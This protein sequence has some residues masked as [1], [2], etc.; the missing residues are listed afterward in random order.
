MAI[1]ATIRFWYQA[2]AIGPS[3]RKKRKYLKEGRLLDGA[4]KQIITD[5]NY[6]REY[7]ANHE[8]AVRNTFPSFW[9]KKAKLE[10]ENLNTFDP[11]SMRIDIPQIIDVLCFL[12]DIDYYLPMILCVYGLLLFLVY[13][14]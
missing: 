9:G 5:S 14:L 3:P 7:R 10:F 8:M 1:F 6:L 12:E 2:V 4:E 11:P 13:H